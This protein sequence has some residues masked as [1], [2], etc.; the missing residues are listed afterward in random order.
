MATRSALLVLV[1][2]CH[3]RTDRSAFVAHS[4]AYGYGMSDFEAFVQ[5][6]LGKR[7]H[8]D[9]YLDYA[10]SGLYTDAQIDAH[11][12]DLKENLYG[13]PHSLSSSATRSSISIQEARDEVL[14]FL[15]ASP[16]EYE[17]VFTRSCTD[18]LRLVADMFPWA[19]GSEYRYLLQN[20]NSVLGIRDVARDM[21]AS[22]TVAW[23]EDVDTWLDELAARPD[24]D[25]TGSLSLFAYPA[26]ENFAG[27]IF[28]LRWASQIGSRKGG[29]RTW[30]VL[31]DAA[32]FTASHP[33]NLTEARADFV[34]LSFYKLF[35]YPT[36]VG[37]LI[38]R[39]ETAFEL[40]KH[41]WGGGS[42]S[43]AGAG[44]TDTDDLKVFKGRIAERFEDGT[45]AFLGIA[46]L[47]H[48][49]QALERVGGM[50]AIEQ[51]TSALASELHRLL[52]RLRH[53][54]G[55]P[56]IAMYSRDRGADEKGRLV[57]GPIVN[58]NVLRADSTLISHI[59]VM[60]TAAEAGIHIRAGMHCNPGAAT[61]IL[62][63]PPEA[64][65]EAAKDTSIQGCGHG[66]AFVKCRASAVQAIQSDDACQQLY[67]G[68]A[69]ATESHVATGTDFLD[70]MQSL[71]PDLEMPF[72]SVRVSVG[73]LSTYE[74]IRRLVDFVIK[75]YQE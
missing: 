61:T 41:Y 15:S 23:H 3:G 12:S 19:S 28:P 4:P 47:K 60:A 32:K 21:N 55:A 44:R 25:A 22:V 75:E 2:G 33:L 20:H 14:Q 26:E 50:V 31:L 63:L 68:R 5:R 11:A 59:E 51:H 37:A 67:T 64:I 18:S 58:F 10:A 71:E 74:D 46:S 17:V 27:Q 53:R 16:S 69:S 72:G 52:T 73:Y 70:A 57:Q 29:L 34:T 56:V 45:L 8:G 36:G 49:F 48:G 6:E 1:V 65:K 66:P 40:K 43:L 7:L 39:Q 30:R 24:Q 13:N 35:G 9:V 54:N 42:V 38:I 62:G